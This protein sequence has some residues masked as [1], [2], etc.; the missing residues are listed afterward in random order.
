M[1]PSDRFL[2]RQQE[3]DPEIEE[4]QHF[5]VDDEGDEGVR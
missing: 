3:L 1:R 4:D 2:T 5:D